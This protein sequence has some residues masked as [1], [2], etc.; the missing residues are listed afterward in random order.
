MKKTNALWVSLAVM[1]FTLGFVPAAEAGC[2]TDHG[3]EKTYEKASMETSEDLMAIYPL[4]EKKGF[5][6]LTTAIRAAML[7]E[8]LTMDGPFTVFAPT[9]EA[10]AALPE[11]ALESLLNDKEALKKVLL[12]HVVKGEVPA[13]DVVNLTEAT[14]LNGKE[15]TVAVV[16]GGVV[17]NSG[18]KVIATDVKAKNGIVHVIDSVLLPPAM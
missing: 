18:T 12:Y 1:L 5:T 9:D 3:K 4:A 17:L 14:T 16:D 13:S 8:T 6:T 15:V 7:Q 2:G 10:F 11:G